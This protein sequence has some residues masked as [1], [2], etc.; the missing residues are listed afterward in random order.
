MNAYQEFKQ[1]EDNADENMSCD[2]KKLVLEYLTESSWNEGNFEDEVRK[3]RNQTISIMTEVSE[4]VKEFE[5]KVMFAD[6][7]LKIIE[8]FFSIDH[9][10]LG[11]E[12]R[13]H[14]VSMNK[15][16]R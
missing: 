11:V 5:F 12:N 8:E 2:L 7:E 14:V 3:E 1:D 16:I 10:V 15:R 13:K 9:P 4:S 6:E